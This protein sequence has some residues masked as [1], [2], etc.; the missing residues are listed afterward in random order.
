MDFSIGFSQPS[1]LGPLRRGW[2]ATEAVPVIIHV[3][4]TGTQEGMTSQQ[5]TSLQMT[6]ETLQVEESW[7]HHGDCIGADADA[8]RVARLIG[9]RIYR[10]PPLNPAKRAF[11]D[12][13]LD[14]KPRDYIPR[15][16][17]IVNASSVL[18]VAPLTPDER[19]RSGT[20]ATARFARNSDV[21]YVIIEPN[22]N[23]RYA[24]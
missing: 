2:S 21:E 1:S 4:F 18:L 20:W 14:S 10:H 8:H 23:K 3:G 9:W 17:D 19:R 13:D 6:L 7:L 16:H 22:G 12:F 11:C 24:F 15:N 5:K